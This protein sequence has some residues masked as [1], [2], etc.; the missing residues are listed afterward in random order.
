MQI[1]TT[2]KIHTK[3]YEN[4]KPN[5]YKKSPKKNLGNHLFSQ[6]VSFSNIQY[7]CVLYFVNFVI[8]RMF[9]NKYE[10]KI[11]KNNTCE[12]PVISNICQ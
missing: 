3:Y 6:I 4:M 9:K 12:A 8:N 1:T 7:S 11:I 5:K 10:T 2:Y